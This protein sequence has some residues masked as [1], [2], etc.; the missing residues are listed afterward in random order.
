MKLSS[1]LLGKPAFHCFLLSPCWVTLNFERR[2]LNFDIKFCMP[3][4]IFRVEIIKGGLC[5][6]GFFCGLIFV[7]WC[8]VTRL[9]VKHTTV[10]LIRKQHCLVLEFSLEFKAAALVQQASSISQPHCASRIFGFSPSFRLWSPWSIYLSLQ[11]SQLIWRALCF[12]GLVG[13]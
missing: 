8:F 6:S 11:I 1:S 7:Q 3:L 12:K 5:C 10:S 4:L 2:L 13:S 9:E